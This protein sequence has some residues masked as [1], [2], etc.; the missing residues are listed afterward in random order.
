MVRRGP[1]RP[2]PEQSTTSTAGA[3][4][5]SRWAGR[6]GRGGGKAARKRERTGRRRFRPAHRGREPRRVRARRSQSALRHLDRP[7]EHVAAAADGTA[8]LLLLHLLLLG[9][10]LFHLFHLGGGVA[11]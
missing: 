7:A 6:C 8:A 11:G 9:L 2:M 5:T 1:P 4:A 3:G 10:L